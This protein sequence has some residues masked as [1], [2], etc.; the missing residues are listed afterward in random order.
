MT[1]ETM[2]RLAHTHAG[3]L[4]SGREVP[5][6]ANPLGARGMRVPISALGGEDTP[7]MIFSPS[8]DIVVSYSGASKHLALKYPHKNSALPQ[9]SAIRCDKKAFPYMTSGVA[10]SQELVP[11]HETDGVSMP[12]WKQESI[13][14]YA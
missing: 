14:P 9:D 2:M 7:S 11:R 8:D 4:H 1:K 6:R 5:G 10:K 12:S 13:H 3:A